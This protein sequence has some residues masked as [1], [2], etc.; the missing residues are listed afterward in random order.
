M[1]GKDPDG[2]VLKSTSDDQ[3]MSTRLPDDNIEVEVGKKYIF[4]IQAIYMEFDL[5]S[6]EV[7]QW[8]K[9]MKFSLNLK[10]K[11]MLFLTIFFKKVEKS[12][13]Y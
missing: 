9:K 7:V 3:R 2:L 1:E 8:V 11:K 12:E 6:A 4:T 13:E 10:F 5:L